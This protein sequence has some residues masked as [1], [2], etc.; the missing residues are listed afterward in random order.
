[1]TIMTLKNTVTAG[2]IAASM[3]VTG[4]STYGPNNQ[5]ETMGTILGGAA[6]AWAGSSIGR[7]DGRIVA[8]AAGTMLGAAIGNQ[9]GR[10]MDELDRMKANRAQQFA[11]AAP[12]GETI[13][14]NNPDSGNYGNVTPVRD[15]YSGSGRYCREFQT[16]VTVDGTRQSGYGTACQQPDGSWQIVS[17]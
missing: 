15:G 1:M 17:Q 5:N 8:T 16:E 7:G 4:C 9:I 6:G 2:V 14:W 13:V 10:S 3:A 12:I 11:Y